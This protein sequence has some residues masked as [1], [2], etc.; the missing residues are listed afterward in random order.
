L[1]GANLAAER[2]TVA[3]FLERW[4]SEMSQPHCPYTCAGHRGATWYSLLPIT[5]HPYVAYF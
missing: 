5:I 3:Q 2:I 1:S 4:L